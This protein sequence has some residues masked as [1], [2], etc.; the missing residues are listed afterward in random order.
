MRHFKLKPGDGSIVKKV[1]INFFQKK[2]PFNSEFKFLSLFQ[3]EFRHIQL[4]YYIN[5][6]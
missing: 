3:H 4:N 1:K 5:I 6:K 2:Q